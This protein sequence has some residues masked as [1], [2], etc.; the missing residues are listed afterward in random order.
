MNRRFICLASICAISLATQMAM[1]QK[2]APIRKAAQPRSASSKFVTLKRCRIQLVDEVTLASERPGII[3]F[4]EPE[5]GDTV[6]S[7]QQVAGL[8]DEVA[9]ANTRIARAKAANDVQVRYAKK[10]SQVA[11]VEHEKAL[12]TNEDLKGTVPEIEIRKLRLAAEKTLL[13]IEQ[14]ENEMVV[15]SFVHDEAIAG[16]KTFRIEA[17]FD[18]VVTRVHKRQGEAVRQGDPIMEVASTRRVRVEGYIALDHI[19]SCK[20]GAPVSIRLDIPGVDLAVEKEK[21][22]GRIVFVDPAVQP[23]TRQARVWA[24]VINRDDILRAGLTATMTIDLSESPKT[25]GRLISNPKKR[26]IKK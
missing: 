10:S 2:K 9:R 21:F 26:L 8:R 19:W 23:V 5:E 7:G 16:L 4:L 11:Q 14:A 3:S 25:P 22:V 12:Q 6:R 15:N 17:P 20:P 1:A 13:Q 24:E 18:G